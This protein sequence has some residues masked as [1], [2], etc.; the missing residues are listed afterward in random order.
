MKDYTLDS[1][2]KGKYIVSCKE[3]D[4]KYKITFADGTKFVIDVNEEN[5]YKI[6]EKYNQ[7]QH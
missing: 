3:E 1:R 6:N 2:K 4:G 5:F 7:K